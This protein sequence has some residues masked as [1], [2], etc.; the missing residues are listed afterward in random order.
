MSKN[1][2]KRI[3]INTSRT[4]MKRLF[5]FLCGFFFLT[6]Q[7]L[8]NST[9]KSLQ[10]IP[11]PKNFE[12]LNGEFSFSSHTKLSS[13]SEK[14]ADYFILQ[15]R[16]LTGIKFENVTD[17]SHNKIT[18]EYSEAP[19]YENKEAYTLDITKDEV[20]IIASG[21]EGLF[22]GMQ[23]FFQLIPPSVKTEKNGKDVSLQCCK[24]SDS[25]EFEWRG[26]NL[27]CCRHFMSKD[28]IKRYIDIL[29]YY[30]FN[31]FHWHLTEDQGWRIEI[32]KYPKLTEIGAWRK[33]ADGSVY[34]GFYTQEDIKE[35]VAYA[36]S[37]FI[38]IVPEIEM[39][40]H[41]IASLAS[42]PENS[43]TG[44]PFEVT[45]IWGVHK[46]IYCAGR[47]STFKFLQNVLDEVI[48]LFPGKYIH[49]GGD[50]AP[51]DRWK[52]CPRCQARIKEEGLKD[53]HELQ[54]Y[55]IKRIVDYL[56]SK[57]KEV[58]GWDEILQGGLAPGAIVQS[59]QGMQGA[60]EAARR[61]HRTICSPTSHTYFDYSADNLDL[62]IVYSFKPI[63]DELSDDEKKF[64]I[65][66][67][68]NM[69]TEYAPQETID[70]KLFPRILALSEVLWKNPLN[71]GYGEFHARLQKCYADLSA[72]GIQYGRESKIITPET[73]YDDT[74]KE[75]IVKVIQGQKNINIRYT[76][77][78]SEPNKNS[79]LY[80]T[81]VIIKNTTELKIAAFNKGYKIGKQYS[82]SFDFHKALNSKL[83]LTYPYDE[84]YRAGGE[85][86]LI[87][88]VKGTD[89]F[90][91][92]NWQG[93]EGVDFEAVIDL[94]D[95]TEISEVNTRFFLNS[96]SWVFLPTKV[97][98]SLSTDNA[99][100]NLTKV[101]PN[102]IS[103]KNSEIVLKDF[104]ANFGKQV[105]RFI[106][107]KAES[108]KKC[109][110][111]HPGAG[112][113]VWMFI[114]EIVVK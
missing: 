103:Q 74:K 22:R 38:N 35:I 78:G 20:R 4:K 67:E 82:L 5:Q 2:S 88:G 73:T 50:E 90:H 97:E 102:D 14:L 21:N 42:Y 49:I 7:L 25:P 63:P 27:D 106:K 34:G 81:P 36:E 110:D 104:S 23:T 60:V 28:F 64:V 17:E 40:G 43:C 96:S 55:F 26:L 62:R 54:S 109:P 53:E 69:W 87:D 79:L 11:L 112:S 18:L 30:K 33:E 75:F 41:S 44:G 70:S 10:I 105:V 114:D 59:W 72:L 71:I 108:I 80:E 8:A 98:I 85:N 12:L 95:L 91:D 89:D 83:T 3:L 16:K 77:D 57:D 48:E 111:W 31:T 99:N 47:D 61:G 84:R 39:P 107:V 86:A 52:E 76:T 65:G 6:S 66:S 94:G 45:N 113:P 32:K 1:N 13:P 93:F 46:D 37:R 58:I 100:Y 101:I 92:G 24:I 29:A 56:H 15:I 51:K 68:A 9:E 19:E